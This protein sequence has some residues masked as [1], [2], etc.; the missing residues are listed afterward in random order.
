MLR[1]RPPPAPR[2]PDAPTPRV[3]PV[4]AQLDALKAEAARAAET[5][6]LSDEAER[7][8]AA[9]A[10]HSW[11]YLRGL[12]GVTS[13]AGGKDKKAAEVRRRWP[14]LRPADTDS[15]L[16]TDKR[17]WSMFHALCYHGA[18]AS[19]LLHTIGSV[20]KAA[21]QA[22]LSAIVEID[23]E[24][25]SS[26]SEADED[27]DEDDPN[28]NPFAT[29]KPQTQALSEEADAEEKNLRPLAAT[30][31]LGNNLLHL[32]LSRITTEGDGH[33]RIT[34]KEEKRIVA[35]VRGILKREPDLVAQRNINGRT[36]L[37]SLLEAAGDGGQLSIDILGL[38]HEHHP[39]LCEDR[40]PGGDLPLHRVCALH[41]PADV[42]AKIISWHPV[43]VRERDRKG[44]TPLHLALSTAYPNV[45][46][47]RDL[48]E[49]WPEAIYAVD[50]LGQTPLLAA[51]IAGGPDTPPPMALLRISKGKSEWTHPVPQL[52]GSFDWYASGTKLHPHVIG[53]DFDGTDVTTPSM[54]VSSRIDRNA[55]EGFHLNDPRAKV[56][57][58]V[59][60]RLPPR[61]N[62]MFLE[63]VSP[64]RGMVMSRP[65]EV[66]ANEHWNHIAPEKRSFRWYAAGHTWGKDFLDETPTAHAVNFFHERDSKATLAEQPQFRVTR[67]YG[68]TG[69]LCKVKMNTSPIRKHRSL[70]KSRPFQLSSAVTGLRRSQIIG[71]LGLSPRYRDRLQRE[72]NQ[73]RDMGRSTV[74][75]TKLHASLRHP[76]VAQP[77][78]LRSET[79]A[80]AKARRRG[81]LRPIKMK[82]PNTV[83]PASPT[84]GSDGGGGGGGG[85]R[86]RQVAF[87]SAP[88][89][90]SEVEDE[91]NKYF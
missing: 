27:D 53:A 62:K 39:T 55:P 67:Q 12:L 19:F 29:P 86:R 63:L 40:G 61:F 17:G 64:K 45:P 66:S 21:E 81:R 57:E 41:S 30:D 35:S 22:R 60:K 5:G 9:C 6:L 32:L 56:K 51:V 72:A 23:E 10:N 84:R 1:P 87:A 71:Q 79:P 52:Y 42:I 59:S 36:P 82:L 25:L 48:L 89:S 3:S 47:V 2:S 49:Q 26:D 73:S 65:E 18:P 15:L 7:L 8:R 24:G 80:R 11:L 68:A 77:M 54:Q 78:L 33:Q 4:R 43:G 44:R 83:V 13:V 28:F 70:H 34:R 20:E 69:G 75:Q 38:L 76:F 88:D 46:V 37:H 14:G 16:E 58:C 50:N 90:D 74:C 91:D 31:H 85:R